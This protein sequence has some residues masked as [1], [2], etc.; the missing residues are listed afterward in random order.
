MNPN[1]TFAISVF[2]DKFGF[3]VLE[4]CVQR[5]VSC[6]HSMT[7]NP[8]SLSS[9][10]LMKEKNE[11]QYPSKESDSLCSTSRTTKCHSNTTKCISFS[12]T[13]AT[14]NRTE[15][16]HRYSFLLQLLWKNQWETIQWEIFKSSILLILEMEFFILHNLQEWTY[17]LL[18]TCY[19]WLFDY[20][21]SNS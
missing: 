3:L 21:Y 12:W 10:I 6:N 20:I 17:H 9:C 16:P 8:T 19:I 14:V 15:Y 11:G 18:I 5:F 13:L 2:E 1:W 4:L 7:A